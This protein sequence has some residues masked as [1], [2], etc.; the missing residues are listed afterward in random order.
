M[1]F[2]DDPC[3]KH[4]FLVTDRVAGCINKEAGA[5]AEPESTLELVRRARINE[6]RRLIGPLSDKESLYCSDAS[7]SRYL[8]LQYWNV[9]KAAQ[10]L[11]QSLKWR[12]EY[13]P[14]EIRW[15]EVAEEAET[16]MMYKPNY[17]D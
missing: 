5:G 1:G 17:H 3:A 2:F 7:I 15:E 4:S 6:V 12:K 9:K 10:M 8:R 13:K 11:K 16:G 14:E